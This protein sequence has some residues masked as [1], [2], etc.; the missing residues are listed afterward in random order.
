MNTNQKPATR[1]VQKN[2]PRVAR[3]AF[4]RNGKSFAHALDCLAHSSGAPS[5]IHCRMAM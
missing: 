2:V 5:A 3:K 4:R 1:E